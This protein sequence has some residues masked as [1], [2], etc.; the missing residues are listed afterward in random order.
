M[1]IR[2]TDHLKNASKKFF[3][4][5]GLEQAVSEYFG[6]SKV[7]QSLSEGYQR[8]KGLL[9][10]A[11][12]SAPED[13]AKLA[14]EV[15][16]KLTMT[17]AAY[18][19]DAYETFKEKITDIFLPAAA[20]IS[21]D[22][23]LKEL[24]KNQEDENL[25]HLVVSAIDEITEYITN[26]FCNIIVLVVEGIPLEIAEEIADDAGDAEVVPI[27]IRIHK[28]SDDE[29]DGENGDEEGGHHCCCNGECGGHCNCE[30]KCDCEEDGH[31]Q[32]E[33]GCN[34]GEHAEK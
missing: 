5:H 32:C 3:E 22:D 19:Q 26:R 20:Y 14:E 7:K 21:I 25:M 28:D 30:G 15:A 6:G 18:E 34:C 16:A 9:E 31:C 4:D 11:K 13:V 29:E 27:S 12:K 10:E 24:F 23:K 1:N 17:E 8:Y 33:N 2:T